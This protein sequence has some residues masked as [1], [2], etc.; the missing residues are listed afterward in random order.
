MPARPADRSS[1][2][3][4]VLFV[5]LQTGAAANGGIA[6]LGEIMSGLT[7][8]RPVLL[9]NR[10]SAATRR[11]AEAGIEVH[12]VPERASEGLRRSPLATGLSYARY[13]IAV[14]R[15][16][17][18]T[19]A[20]VV[21]ANDPL[22]FQLAYAAARSRPKVRIAFNLRDTLPP[23]RSGYQRLYDWRFAHAD[24]TFFL[25][26]DMIA[27]WRRLAPAAGGNSSATYS[28]VD[29]DRF[30]PLPLSREKPRV[31]LLSGV[32]SAKKGQLGYLRDVAPVLARNGIASWLSGDFAN[33]EVGYAEQC[34]AAAEPL[35]DMVRFLGYREDMPALLAR[36]HVLCVASRYEGLMRS[37]IEAMAAGRPVVSTDVASAREMLERPGEIAGSV[38]PLEPGPAMA[39]ELVRLC[40]DED[41]NRA[42]GAN[43]ARIARR[44]MSR[45]AV[46]EAYESR[47]DDLAGI[48]AT[49]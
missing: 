5:A 43:G 25:S 27:R 40:G 46:V 37:M 31:V 4:A 21:H 36:A 22:A 32:I 12:V 17:A 10:E 47:Y 23:E 19:G 35:G 3:P 18:A 30:A 15:L 34:R 26:H 13:F 2:P 29:R 28:I 49:A 38:V 11:W 20:R 14:R 16:L 33:D 7:R 6:S 48:R 1:A 42:M 8:Y 24:H 41:A 44:L 39:H 9:T 45:A